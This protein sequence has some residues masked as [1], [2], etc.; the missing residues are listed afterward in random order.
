MFQLYTLISNSSLYCIE[1]FAVTDLFLLQQRQSVGQQSH[2]E[3]SGG[4]L[5][6]HEGEKQLGRLAEALLSVQFV[7]LPVL[8]YERQD[9]SSFRLQHRLRQFCLIR[10]KLMLTEMLSL[11]SV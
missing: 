1:H 8:P 9:S 6:R 11:S 2:P 5:C 3:A 7:E 10:T 4:D